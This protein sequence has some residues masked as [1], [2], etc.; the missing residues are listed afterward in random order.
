MTGSKGPSKRQ[1]I[2]SVAAGAIP[3]ILTDAESIYLAAYRAMDDE[4]RRMA[5]RYMQVLAKEFPRR[6]RLRL[7]GADSI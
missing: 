2:K 3:P 5:T 4:A 1:R 6:P 7:V